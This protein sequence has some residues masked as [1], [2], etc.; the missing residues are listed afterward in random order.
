MS[1]IGGFCKG[2]AVCPDAAGGGV[3]CA[4]REKARHTPKAAHPMN[5]IIP[6]YSAHRLPLSDP[7]PWSLLTRLRQRRDQF[8]FV[9]AGEGVGIAQAP[10]P[11]D[12]RS[13]GQ[14]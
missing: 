8:V 4:G 11:E 6:V 1:V 14:N 2:D 10:N 13:R 12:H 3:S 7:V 9:A 5:R